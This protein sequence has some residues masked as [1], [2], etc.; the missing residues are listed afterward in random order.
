MAE[1]FI[2]TLKKK[3]F[4]A[5]VDNLKKYHHDII[6][7]LSD[8]HE[9][10]A[11]EMKYRTKKKIRTSWLQKKGLLMIL[12][13]IGIIIIKCYRRS[14]FSNFLKRRNYFNN[15]SWMQKD[16]SNIQPKPQA[17]NYMGFFDCYLSYLSV[18][19]VHHRKDFQNKSKTYQEFPRTKLL[20]YSFLFS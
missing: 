11:Q 17:K 15:D 14:K 3:Q 4:F 2:V 19:L 6:Y 8:F 9:E 10:R 16:D 20:Y 12:N 5:S 1:S 7:D 13:A 18:A